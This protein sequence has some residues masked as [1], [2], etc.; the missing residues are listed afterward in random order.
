MVSRS[1]LRGP[2]LR[3]SRP[4]PIPLPFYYNGR[5]AG[6]SYDSTTSTI[7]RPLK[8]TS[9]LHIETPDSDPESLLFNSDVGLNQL[10]AIC[11]RPQRSN[12]KSQSRPK[13]TNVLVLADE[14]RIATVAT[15]ASI[16]RV[17]GTR[18]P[19]SV[20][21]KHSQPRVCLFF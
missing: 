4:I 9:H 3:L 13:P 19:S 5:D 10:P 16:E 8:P 12:L 18:N 14:G 7:S 21:I 2:T 6:C 1:N 17:W 11:I 15:I 20:A